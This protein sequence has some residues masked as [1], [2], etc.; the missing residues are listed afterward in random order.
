[1]NFHKLNSLLSTRLSQAKLSS[2]VLRK[3]CSEN[4][5]RCAENAENGF[6]VSRIFLGRYHKDGEE[7][8]DH[9][10]RITGD[11]TWISFVN[12]ETKEQ[13]K[14]WMHTHE[15]NNSKKFKQT[16]AC[17]KA[18][19]NFFLG[20]ERSVDVIHGTRDR[21]DLRN[22]LRNTQKDCV[23]PAIQNK[24]REMLTYS[25]VL[26]LTVRVRVRVQ[27]LALERCWSISTGSCLAISL[28]ATITC[29]PG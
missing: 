11:E 1:V 15:P 16:Y 25:V 7:F 26:L 2:Q 29:L 10:I 8:L 24:R 13:P 3:I 6:G 22:L 18:D 14:Q 21:N 12:V 27:L 5:H 9:I 20:Q 28:R 17:Q 23:G 19:G 4:A